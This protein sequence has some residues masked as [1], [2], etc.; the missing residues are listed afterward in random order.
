M[1]KFVNLDFEKSDKIF[2]FLQYVDEFK[3]QNEDAELW[4]GGQGGSPRASCF[5]D[6][7]EPK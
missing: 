1:I 5:G 6:K 7:K 4:Y 2:E 3:K